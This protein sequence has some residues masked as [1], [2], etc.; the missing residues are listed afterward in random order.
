MRRQLAL[1]A[2]HANYGDSSLFLNGRN[3]DP[4]RCG[5][6]GQRMMMDWMLQSLVV[7]AWPPAPRFTQALASPRDDLLP[8]GT[9]NSP[10]TTSLDC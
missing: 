3:V 9:F 10:Q 8:P 2:I 4:I 1:K 7:S 5:E 6:D